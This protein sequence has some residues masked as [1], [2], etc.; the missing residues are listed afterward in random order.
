MAQERIDPIYKYIDEKLKPITRELREINENL[1]ESQH[2][3][4]RLLIF[5]IANDCRRTVLTKKPQPNSLFFEQ[6]TAKLTSALKELDISSDPMSVLV[7]FHNWCFEE[8]EKLGI[9]FIK[10]PE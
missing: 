6:L 3:I 2:V 7:D 1:L 9:T 4:A 8:Q 10:P 5:D